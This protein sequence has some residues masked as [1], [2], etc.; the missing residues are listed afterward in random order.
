MVSSV[1]LLVPEADDLGNQLDGQAALLVEGDREVLAVGPGHLDDDGRF[2]T[3]FFFAAGLVLEAFALER[4]ERDR[5]DLEI[6]AAL[7]VGDAV[8]FELREVVAELAPALVAGKDDDAVETGRCRT[9]GGSG[10]GP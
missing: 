7:F 9:P 3:H 2:V 8:A 1:V 4:H 6:D 10:R 5:D